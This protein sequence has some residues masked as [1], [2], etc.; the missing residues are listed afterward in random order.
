VQTGANLGFAGGNNVG[1]RMALADKSCEFAWLLNN[2]TVVES[3]TLRYLVQRMRERPDAGICGST[4]V[5]YHDV[6][7]IQAQ[8]GSTYNLWLARIGHIGAGLRAGQRL[9]EDDVE[10]RLRYVMGASMMIRRQ[11]LERIGLLD[12]RYFLYFE[13]VDLCTRA[14]K[15]YKLAYAAQSVVYHKEGASIGS[16]T[17]KGK[18]QSAK[19]QLY[20]SR[21]RIL[22]TRA[23]FPPGLLTVVPSVLV[24]TLARLFTGRFDEFVHSLMG[25][26]AG[27]F[28]KSH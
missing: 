20:A 14:R 21:N 16:S 5:Y 8:G 27:L 6:N 18:R 12:E 4:L 7:T 17:V 15:S 11:V 22:F 24:S 25:M 9:R 28:R 26:K 2:D 3:D 23:H 1:L 19:A 13:E 10:S